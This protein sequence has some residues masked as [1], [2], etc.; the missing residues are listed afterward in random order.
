MR[1]REGRPTDKAILHG[2]AVD[3]TIRPLFPKGYRNDVQVVCR[4]VSVEK[5]NI[6]EI[7]AI[8]AA[9]MALLL[10]SIP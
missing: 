7:L 3:R 9:S 8:N 5:D 1:K 10:S 2:R 6:P 4:V